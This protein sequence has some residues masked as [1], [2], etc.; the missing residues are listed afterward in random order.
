MEKTWVHITRMLYMSQRGVVQPKNW[1]AE[2]LKPMRMHARPPQLVFILW[3]APSD[4]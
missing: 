3:S 4:E 1:N 2:L